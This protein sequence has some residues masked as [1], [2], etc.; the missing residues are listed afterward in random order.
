[1]MGTI[2]Q[3]RYLSAVLM[4]AIWWGGFTFYA[5]AVVPT[6]HKVLRSKVRQGFI[7]QRVTEKLNYVGIATVVLLVWQLASTRS[8]FS[9]AARRI[10]W[11]SWAV[12][13]ATLLTLFLMHPQLGALLDANARSVI[14]D[15]RFYEWHRWYLIVATVQWLAG[16]ALFATLLR[17]PSA[18]SK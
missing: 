1:M 15:T 11:S 17:K 12:L 18:H 14:D 4:L 2:R 7:T 13:A 10:G 3:F 8:E 9:R 6:G 5:L 16:A